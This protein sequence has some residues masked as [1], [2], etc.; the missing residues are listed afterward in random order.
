M[1]SS[2][3]VIEISLSNNNLKGHLKMSDHDQGWAQGKK[4]NPEVK[5]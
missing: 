1:T 2:I 4:K 5:I 3:L